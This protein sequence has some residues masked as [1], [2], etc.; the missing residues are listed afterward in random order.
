MNNAFNIVIAGVGGQGL[1]TLTQILAE[2][3]LSEG[4]D[5]KTSELHG[6][7]QRGGSIETYIKFGKKVYSP[8]VDPGKADLIISLELQ[9]GL[10]KIGFSNPKTIFVV[11]DSFIPYHGGLEEEEVKGKLSTLL[12]K[13]LHLVPASLVCKKEL[14]NEVVSGIYL[15]GFC[16]F[17][18][19]IPLKPESVLKAIEK[20][21][22]AKHLEINRQSCHLAKNG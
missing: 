6:I 8:L 11:N 16:V 18:N 15:L 10:R 14:D 12:K 1:I 22:P 20:N 4:Y 21:V 9:E 13:R 2:A 3:A 17:R 19:L 7:A 5:V